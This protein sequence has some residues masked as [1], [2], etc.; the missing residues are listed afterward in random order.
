VTGRGITRDGEVHSFNEDTDW[1][2]PVNTTAVGLM[3]RPAPTWDHPSFPP[4]A[5]SIT[6][7]DVRD[8]LGPQADELL[9][10]ANVD[11][12]ELIRLINAETTV[13]PPL[14]IPDTDEETE[15]GVPPAALVEAV[16]KWKRRFLK[17][18]VAAVLV[19]ISGGGATAIAMDK[20]VT[21]DVDGQ[22]QTLRTYESTVGEVLKDEGITVGEHDALSPSPQA[23]L[24]DGGKITL[25][26]GRLVKMKVDG[27]QREGWVRSV[28]VDEALK[29][30]NVPSDGAWVSADRKSDVPLQGMNLE[31]K[32][33]KTIT[34]YD[35]ANE[36]RQIKTNAVTVDE[37]LKS[38]KLSLGAEDAIE[39]GIDLKITSGAEVHISRTGVSVVNQTEAVQPPVEEIA[40]DS[41]MKGE[42]KV[43]DPG[44]PGE[45]IVTYRVT[46]KN[47]KEIGRE[48]L[49]AKVTK[50]PKAKKVRKGSKLPPDGAIWDKLAYCEATGNWAINTGNGFYGGLQFDAQTWQAYGG[51]QY[52]SLPHQASREQ[53]IAIASKVRDARGN[54]SAWPM[55]RSKLGLP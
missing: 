10:T 47:G 9:A 54:Y 45:Q 14:V 32:S 35:G 19:T 46:V 7:E 20:S 39:P 37:L 51:D 11:V 31:V 2:T 22:E 3:E 41:M 6:P 50:E 55:C 12:D 8:V 33:L 48:K 40:D 23:K 5:L 38:E 24:G 27:E 15:P 36:P 25:D 49:G 44:T 26:R 13:M 16:G 21:V 53:Q 29:Q 28:T 4:G 1:F 43:E 34:L 42:Q 52:A 18:A 30:L 17:T